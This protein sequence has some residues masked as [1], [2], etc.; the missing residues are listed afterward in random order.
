MVNHHCWPRGRRCLQPLFRRLSGG[1]SGRFP[2]HFLGRYLPARLMTV[3]WALLG[4]TV[5]APALSQVAAVTAPA[6]AT[7][8]PPDAALFFAPSE[9]TSAELSP[10][11]QRLAMVGHDKKLGRKVLYVLHIGSAASARPV[12]AVEGL[13]VHDANWVGNDWLVFSVRDS[14]SGSDSYRSYARGLFSVRHD[15]GSLRQLIRRFGTSNTTN[16]RI[17]ERALSDQHY[18]MHVPEASTESVIVGE[19]RF[20]A[21]GDLLEVLP[22]K[23]NVA[24]GEV[25]TLALGAPAGSRAWFFDAQGVARLVE[26]HLDGRARVHWKGRDA[27]EWT[28]LADHPVLDRPWR[29]EGLDG[30][31]SLFVV[32]D[33][34]PARTR[35]LKRFDIAKKAPAA[36]PFVSA[37]GFDYWGSLVRQSDGGPVLGVTVVTDASSTVWLDARL[38]QVQEAVDKLLPGRINLVR[39]RPC[40]GDDMRVVVLSWSDRVPASFYI[41]SPASG[42]LQGLGSSR[43]DIERTRMG[44]LDLHRIKARDGRDLPLWMTLPPGADKPGKLPAV[45]LVHSSANQRDQQWAWNPMAQFLATRGYVVLQPETR[46]LDGYGEDHHRAGW[47]QWGLARQD[48]LADAVQW[49]VAAGWVDPARVCAVGEWY[50]GYASLMTPVRHPGLVRCLAAAGAF[51]EPRALLQRRDDG[52]VNELA[53]LH[54]LP[55][56]LGDL[57]ADALQLAS[58]SAVEQAARINTPVLLAYGLADRLGTVAAGQALRAGLRAAGREPVWI[59]YPDENHY[60]LKPETWVDYA[61]HLDRFLAEHLGPGAPAPPVSAS[62]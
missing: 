43:P 52:S 50:G 6:A 38:R 47:K 60:W 10:S 23:L 37:P 44:T 15:G 53:R 34:G 11:G 39:C 46:G 59:T 14:Q 45:L 3:L 27:H 54:Y 49:A 8:A 36:T 17:T 30:D 22:K 57:R 32:D 42:K 21:S 5:A 40:T 20:D 2:G 13:D 1:R 35:V 7:P 55:Q 48:D 29:P 51:A 18:L 24:T 31:D 26:S 61:R 16:S 56:A 58:T 28:L 62:R 33:S 25:E 19:R 12:A 41:Y 4:C 9:L